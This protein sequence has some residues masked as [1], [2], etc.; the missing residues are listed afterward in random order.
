MPSIFSNR[1]VEYMPYL[2]TQGNIA[3]EQ[4]QKAAAKAAAAREQDAEPASKRDSAESSSTD[5]S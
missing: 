4:K 1:I 5:R 3:R 2:E